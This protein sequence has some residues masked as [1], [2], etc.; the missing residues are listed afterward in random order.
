MNSK[1]L[2][3][4]DRKDQIQQDDS[5][6]LGNPV[7]DDSHKRWDTDDTR[8]KQIWERYDQTVAK[9]IVHNA[10]QH[11]DVTLIRL[12]HSLSMARS[13]C[14]REKNKKGEY[15]ESGSGS[16]AQGVQEQVVS[17]Y[18]GAFQEGGSK[19]PS[20]YEWGD[21]IKCLLDNRIKNS[22]K[23][24]YYVT[25]RGLSLLHQYNSNCSLKHPT[26]SVLDR[27]EPTFQKLII[28]NNFFDFLQLS[29]RMLYNL[30][31]YPPITRG[32]AAVNTWI[33]DKIATEKFN[34]TSSLRP[35]LYDWTAFLETS[36]NYAGFYVISAA[37]K[38]LALIP[39]LYKSDQKFYDSIPALMMADPNKED[40]LHERKTAWQKIQNNVKA[41]LADQ[42][43]AD[44]LSEQQK[45]ALI[46]IRDGAILFRTSSREMVT[47][48]DALI[49][50]NDPVTKDT[51]L[52][53]LNQANLSEDLIKELLQLDNNL[54]KQ[55][56][57]CYG[58]AHQE[59][60]LNK[61][62]ANL[63]I[64]RRLPVEKIGDLKKILDIKDIDEPMHLAFG[65]A[66]MS[67][68]PEDLTASVLKKQL[69]NKPSCVAFDN[70]VYYVGNNTDWA[71]Q[72]I[73]DTHYAK[74]IIELIE[75]SKLYSYFIDAFKYDI[76]RID[77][78]QL[79]FTKISFA[80]VHDLLKLPKYIFDLLKDNNTTPLA[81]NLKDA[82]CSGGVMIQ[83][84]PELD[85]EQIK[86][87]SSLEAIALYRDNQFIRARD[88]LSNPPNSSKNENYFAVN[89]NYT[90]GYYVLNARVSSFS[91]L[92]GIFGALFNRRTASGKG[93]EEGSAVEQKL[94]ASD[95]ENHKRG[96]FQ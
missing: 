4:D 49:S 92:S 68:N 50:Q 54:S 53:M 60:M 42:T 65:F 45:A 14:E 74:S 76:L 12:Y 23:N 7:S 1:S 11:K 22:N 19:E 44:A 79:L 47:F 3:I 93:L 39:D 6:S 25:D 83:D 75:E 96:F 56:L 9:Q 63:E 91:L 61:Q 51:L 87:I 77:S 41:Y 81:I 8:L 84:L 31:N 27:L 90:F 32:S 57:K 58:D 29:A 73:R 16:Q 62:W 69:D 28:T 35:L 66:K 85:I 52:L 17:E 34:V 43:H 20:I 55:Y 86:T 13:S 67:S 46:S 72:K 36:D 48:I 88:I 37:V 71:L 64:L 26:G 70:M 10:L 38:Y 15:S 24:D 59:A 78:S 21:I 95:S 30:S 94:P 5:I 18:F 2:E 80:T 33:I 40:A 82:I 89:W